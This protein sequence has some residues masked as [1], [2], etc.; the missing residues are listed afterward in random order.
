[1]VQ[2]LLVFDAGWHISKVVI[3]YFVDGDSTLSAGSDYQD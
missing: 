3:I 1:M 2:G